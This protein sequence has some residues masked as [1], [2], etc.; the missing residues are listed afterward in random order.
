V[1][2]AVPDERRHEFS[3]IAELSSRRRLKIGVPLDIDQLQY[4]IDR[5][6]DARNTEFVVL[7]SGGRFFEG[8]HPELD[9]FL[10]PAE[11]GAAAT[12]LHPQYTIVVPQ[13]DPVGIPFAFGVALDEGELLALVNEWVVFAENEGRVQRA[14]DYWVLG[15]GAEDHGPRWSILRDVLGWVD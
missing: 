4:S 1:G 7:E 8:D 12:L 10:L 3:E 14:D 11:S 15:R 5:Y 9:A 6:F 13:P 2:L